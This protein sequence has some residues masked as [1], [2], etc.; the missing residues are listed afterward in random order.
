MLTYLWLYLIRT[1]QSG[2]IEQNPGTKPNSC[3]SYSNRHW[4][5]KSILPHNFIKLSLL[6]AYIAI[7]EFDYVLI[8][9]LS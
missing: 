6:R 8:R 5:L 7:H 4:N 3:R 9:N 1:K 2:D